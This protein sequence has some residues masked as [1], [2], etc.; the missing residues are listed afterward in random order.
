MDDNSIPGAL[1]I[2]DVVLAMA[3]VVVTAAVVTSPILVNTA[4]TPGSERIMN[5]LSV[6]NVSLA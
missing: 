6:L 3:S 1:A 4:V 5:L 2:R